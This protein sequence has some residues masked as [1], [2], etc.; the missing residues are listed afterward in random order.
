M[1][2]MPAMTAKVL[3]AKELQPK[4]NGFRIRLSLLDTGTDA[5][6]RQDE[7]SMHCTIP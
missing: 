6:L 5:F 3:S 2:A 7:R 1:I 4:P